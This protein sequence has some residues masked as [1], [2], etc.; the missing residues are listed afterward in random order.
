MEEKNITIF[1]SWQSDLNKKLN[2]S[3]I[4]H[5]ISESIKLLESELENVNIKLD[6]STSNT[7][8]SP[9]ISE[10]IFR[11]I[12]ACDIFVCDISIINSHLKSVDGKIR[13]TPNPNV[14]V[15]LGY[16][17]AILGWERIILVVNEVYGKS[18]ELPFD[19]SKHRA[20][21]YEITD[22]KDNN[23]KGK[24]IN[25]FKKAIST[26]IQHNPPKACDLGKFDPDKVKRKRDI[27]T[28][29]LILNN[30]AFRAFESFFKNYPNNFDDY[31]LHSNDALKDITNN[32]SFHIYD[33][34]LKKYFLRFQLKFDEILSRKN[35]KYFVSDLDI[36]S[37]EC[38]FKN[39]DNENVNEVYSRLYDLKYEFEEYFLKLINY[40]KDNYIEIDFTSIEE[41]QLN[42]LNSQKQKWMKK[43]EDLKDNTEN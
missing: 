39:I 2:R 41:D 27:D 6:D 18:M 7:P 3:L 34:N 10:I 20:I 11:K 15:E 40:I 12:S 4:E 42:W 28:I 21:L 36:N 1:Y 23:N 16:A 33:E 37:D 35:S 9:N 25:G 5:S 30:I 32:I 29:N 38:R 17:I 43:H 8:G 13:L 19:I 22:S 14:L 31:F 26:I 24:L